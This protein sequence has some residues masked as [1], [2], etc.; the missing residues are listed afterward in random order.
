M[1]D[2]II[3]QLLRLKNNPQGFYGVTLV[4][5]L[6]LPLEHWFRYGKI[7]PSFGHEWLGWLIATISMIQLARIQKKKENKNGK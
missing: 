4:I 2:Y 5:G 3:K 1:I 7:D 6:V